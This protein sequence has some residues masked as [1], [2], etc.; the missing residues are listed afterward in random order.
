MEKIELKDAFAEFKNQ[1]NI[2]RPTMMGVLEDVFRTQ[3]T[4]TYGSADNF[5]IIINIDKGDCEIYWNREVVEE[6]ED[7]NTEI[8]I[9]DESLDDDYE[10]GETFAKKIELKDFGRRGILNIRQNLQGRI[11]DIEKA[12]LYNKYVGKIGE[13]FT[14]EVYQTWAKE[15]LILDEDGN[16]LRLPKSEQIPGEHFKKNDTVRAIIKSVEMKNNTTPY[17]VLSRTTPEFLE[18]LFENEVPEILDGLITVKKVV[19][20]PGERAKVAVESYDERI[21]PIGACIGVK[22]ARI[23][24]I[25]RELRNENIDVLQWTN[26]TQLLI[27]RALNPAK[28]SSIVLG[29]EEDKIKVYMLPD[30]VKKGIGKGGCNIRLAGMLVGK[31]IEVWRELPKDDVDAEEE[32]VLLSEFDDVIDAWVIERLQS[33]GCDT[34]K[35]VLALSSAD[36]ARRADLEDET[37]EEIM[38]ILRAEFEDEE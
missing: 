5:D 29:G 22:G 10:I 23:I 20:I 19:R 30:E 28:I 33:I 18:K 37:V 36:I 7:P 32:D 16:E 38:D 21:D 25:V 34:A 12:N 9:N 17:I 6:V 27:Q 35:S 2:D 13:I 1:K 11:M 3:I 8:A 26:N 15:V 14:G 24:G 4:K 31:E